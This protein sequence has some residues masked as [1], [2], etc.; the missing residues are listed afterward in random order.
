MALLT[1][2]DCG[3]QVSTSAKACPKCGAKIPKTKWWLWVPLAVVFVFFVIGATS[4]PK[5]T[6][7]LAE[8][9]TATCM[10]RQGDGE[11]RASSGITLETFCRLKG[12]TIGLRKACQLDPSK[13]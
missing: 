2:K 13:C 5:D 12:A 7:E 9:E 10:R 6:V 1:C 3:T 8:M 11:W 4:G